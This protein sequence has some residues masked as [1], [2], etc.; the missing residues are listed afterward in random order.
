MLCMRGLCC[1]KAS[2]CLSVRLSHRHCVETAKH[3]IKLFTPSGIQTIPGFP[4]QTVRQYLQYSDE[5]PITAVSN[6]RGMKKSRFSTNIS[7]YLGNDTRYGHSHYRMRIGNRTKVL[8]GTVFNDL[9]WPLTQISRS[10]HNL[11]LNISETVRDTAMRNTNTDPYTPYLSVS[12][13][14][15]LSETSDLANYLMTWSTARSLR[16]LSF[17]YSDAVWVRWAGVSHIVSDTL[18]STRLYTI[19]PIPSS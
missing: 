1:R 18:V 8:N 19:N 4:Q 10:R 13:R 5:S 14:M 9:E 17:L 6:A 15:I 7:L 16:Q 11:T 12:F 2:V 3:I